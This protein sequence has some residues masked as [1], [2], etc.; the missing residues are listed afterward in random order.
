MMNILKQYLIYNILRLLTQKTP[1]MV[2]LCEVNPVSYY[3]L[4]VL[5]VVPTG[6]VISLSFKTF[7]TTVPVTV[8]LTE[9]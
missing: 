1:L 8:P 4:V 3:F 9:T 6:S 7:V 5:L 2:F